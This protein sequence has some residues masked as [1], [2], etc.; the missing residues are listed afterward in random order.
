MHMWGRATVK[1]S[2]QVR[3]AHTRIAGQ[4]N[5]SGQRRAHTQHHMADSKPITHALQNREGCEDHKQQQP[6]AAAA[7]R[8]FS[9]PARR[10]A[11]YNPGYQ[12]QQQEGSRC[13]C[14]C[15]CCIT[16]VYIKRND[17]GSRG[18]HIPGKKNEPQH[19]HT[20]KSR[21]RGGSWGVT[22]K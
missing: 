21:E 6:A 12:L 5:T 14:G 8:Q 9:P 13:M 18:G 19:M 17:N 2:R 11:R 20:V 22:E 3:G 4:H 16:P 10:H 15:C 1:Q 7:D